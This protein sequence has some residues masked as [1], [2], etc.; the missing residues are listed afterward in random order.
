MSG[1]VCVCMFLCG[2]PIGNS[3]CYTKIKI[4]NWVYE[5]MVINIEVLHDKSKMKKLE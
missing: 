2:T 3:V 1:R 4:N 5:E